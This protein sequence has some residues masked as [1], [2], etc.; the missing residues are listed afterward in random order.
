MM[1]LVFTVDHKL[2]TSS[3]RKE[4]AQ[5]ISQCSHLPESAVCLLESVVGLPESVVGLMVP[6]SRNGY[7]VC[8]ISIPYMRCD[9]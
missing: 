7:F 9:L 2:Q 1:L 5:G 3:R 6:G 8:Y 4:N